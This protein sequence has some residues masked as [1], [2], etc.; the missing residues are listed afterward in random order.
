LNWGLINLIFKIL[1][2][3]SNCRRNNAVSGYISV[4]SDCYNSCVGVDHQMQNFILAYS[5]DSIHSMMLRRVLCERKY[6]VSNVRNWTIAPRLYLLY[7]SIS[8][9]YFSCGKPAIARHI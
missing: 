8:S 9:K 3:Q 4:A 1:K 5:L 7:L 6:I 2:V